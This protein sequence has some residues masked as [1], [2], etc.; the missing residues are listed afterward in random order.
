MFVS[1]VAFLTSILTTSRQCASS[2]VG[3][4]LIPLIMFRL[5]LTHTR[6]NGLRAVKLKL[7]GGCLVCRVC[8]SSSL[9]CLCLVHLSR[10]SRWARLARREVF[11]FS[12]F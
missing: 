6:L 3:F 2:C 7:A 9:S 10:V 1:R 5:G 8:F 12:C 11:M 4:V